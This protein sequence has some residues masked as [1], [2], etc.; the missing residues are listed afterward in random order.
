MQ[1]FDW[2]RFVSPVIAKVIRNHSDD[3]GIASQQ[4]FLDV[5][6]KNNQGQ[7][8]S[9]SSIQGPSRWLG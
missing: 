4:T 2:L 7:N 1:S 6:A 3:A 8:G 5:T 9:K